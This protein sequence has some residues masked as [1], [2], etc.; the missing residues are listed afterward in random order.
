M[1]SYA[2]S[3][4]H[5]FCLINSLIPNVNGF[6]ISKSISLLHRYPSRKY[7]LHGTNHES[8]LES[9]SGTFDTN[10]PHQQQQDQNNNELPN[11]TFLAKLLSRFQGDFDNYE[12]VYQDRQNGMTPKEGGGHEH[13]HV[14]LLPLDIRLL[15]NQFLM[16]QDHEE[17]DQQKRKVEGA[18]LASYYFNGIPS[19]IFR[20]RLYTFTTTGSNNDDVNDDDAC[21]VEMKLYTLNPKLEG[22]LRQSS[23]DLLSS[24]MKL[25]QQYI[26]NEQKDHDD[27]NDGL[28]S[29]CTELKR[30]DILWTKQPDPIR[31]SYFTTTIPSNTTITTNEIIEKEKVD[32]SNAFHAIMMNDHDIGG[33]LLESQMIPGLQLR[34][35]DELSLWE[36]ELWVNDRGHND[37]TGDMVYGNYLGIPYKMKRVSSLLV[38]SQNND[39]CDENDASSSTI[40]FSRKILDSKLSW[41]LGDEFRTKEEYMS[42]MKDIGVVDGVR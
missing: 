22:Q 30:C 1:P 3:Y 13:F 41:T 21:K 7:H 39:E 35:Q 32:P 12:Q 34:I 24:W 37:E 4:I 5:L 29:F 25:I 20:L 16:N 23:D 14:T 8:I 31:H 33:V 38:D 6:A 2:Q 42:K 27:N 26:I 10:P 28:S 17:E 11:N 15:P 18:V 19:K 36:N 40:R 9:T